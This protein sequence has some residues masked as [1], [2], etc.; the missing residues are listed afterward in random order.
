MKLDVLLPTVSMGITEFCGYKSGE[1]ISDHDVALSYVL[2]H[3]PNVLPSFAGLSKAQQDSIKF[4]HCKLDYNMGWL[5]Q[6]EAPPGA[7]FKSFRK[8]VISGHASASDI[9]F[10]FVHWF[11][12]LAGAEP[13]P[14]QGSEKFVLKFP[15]KVLGNFIDS[16]SVVWTLGSDK[17]ETQVLEDYLLW[18]WNK[19]EPGLGAPPTGPGAIAQM[20]LV[21]MAQGDSHEVLRQFALLP[22][23]DRQVLSEE[24]AMTG[25][26]DQVFERE[27]NTLRKG[28]GPA[29]LVYY[30]PALMQNSGRVD[31]R[32]ALMVLAEVFRQARELWPLTSTPKEANRTIIVQI[33]ALKDLQI[34]AM[35]QPTE[36]HC[37]VLH[38]KSG[39]DGMVKLI[40][41]ASLR[42][43][44]W[45]A[46]QI[47]TF[48]DN[49]GRRR[50]LLGGAYTSV[51]RLINRQSQGNAASVG[52]VH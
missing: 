43:L 41:A 15:Q 9:A 44:D 34:P 33:A 3:C 5:V 4:T 36:G 11:A 35:F 13:Y 31:P 52:S 38:K 1:T 21:L 48:A 16:F 10:Y 17:T 18:R 51:L 42:K 20:R 32:S 49:R 7:L 27:E 19:H 29:I 24:M 22:D 2:E 23:E 46:N 12:D 25:V 40:P 37:F 45:S 26:M 50:N 47:L 14:M 8:V 28:Q 30:S 6:A 39:Q